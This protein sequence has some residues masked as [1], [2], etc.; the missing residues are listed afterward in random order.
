MRSELES[1]WNA[2]DEHSL[3]NEFKE[4]FDSAWD[5]D[6]NVFNLQETFLID[7]KDR[8]P[9]KFSSEFGASIIRLAFAFYKHV[10]HL[11]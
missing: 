4:L 9:K 6:Q 8:A 2:I 3:P 10:I 1:I 5:E 11:N 7:Y